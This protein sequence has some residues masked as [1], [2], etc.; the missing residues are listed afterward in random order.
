MHAAMPPRQRWRKLPASAVPGGY[1]H[2]LHRRLE[3]PSPEGAREATDSQRSATCPAWVTL[4]PA[5]LVAGCMCGVLEAA[6]IPPGRAWAPTDTFKIVGQTFLLAPNGS[7]AVEPSQPAFALE[8]F[9]PNPSI[10]DASIAFTLPAPGLAILEVTD[11]A[12][13]RV[14]RRDVGALGAGRHVLKLDSAAPLGP[15]VYLIRLTR[16]AHAVGTRGDRSVNDWPVAALRV[17]FAPGPTAPALVTR[18]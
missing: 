6:A 10:R 4:V 15:G 1:N 17:G 8:G 16:G 5:L 9:V 2:I 18:A 3:T 7:V 12:G 13:R 11:I 14:F